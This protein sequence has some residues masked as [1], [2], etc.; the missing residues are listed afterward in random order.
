LAR[1]CDGESNASR[2]P[3]A[4]TSDLSETSVSLAGEAGDAPTSNDTGESVTAG[5]GTDIYRLALGKHLRDVN[6]LLKETLGKGNLGSNIT[7]VNLNLKEIGHLGSELQLANLGVGEDAD[8]LAVV[9]DALDLSINLRWL[10]RCLLG[11]LGE[12]LPLAAV[13]VLVKSALD[14][15]RQVRCPNGGK[16]AE[17]GGGGNIAN[18]ANRNHGRSFQNGYTLYCLLLVKFG[19][20]A[21]DLSDNVGH[22]SLV[23]NEGGHVALLGSIILG[24]GSNATVV[25]LGSLLGKIL[26]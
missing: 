11:I 12:S 26:E 5:S 10:L 22:T 1:A 4:D 8:H 19:A 25:V 7:S 16:S 21:L 23:S 20:R 18:H 15:V 13:P 6:L 9:D 14:L 17:T 24:E 3:G 2:V